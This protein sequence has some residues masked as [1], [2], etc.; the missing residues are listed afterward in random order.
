MLDAFVHGALAGYAIAI[1]VG[2]IAVLIIETGLQRG[3]AYG[4][5]AGTGAATADLIYATIA[6]SLGSIVA[7]WLAPIAFALKIASAGFLIMLGGWGF[8]KSWGARQTS[9]TQR[10]IPPSMSLPQTYFTLAG[11]TILNPA[12]I[13]YFGALILGL[14]ADAQPTVAERVLFVAGAFIS[15]WSWQSLLAM[16]GSMAHKYLPPEFRT[17]TGLIG[18]SIIVVLGIKI[19]V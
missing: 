19:L 1:P 6:S 13:A 8:W 9:E 7:V 17:V 12:T 2:A 15:S 11:L 3:F 5:A 10:K 18:N 14:N 4:F 16:L